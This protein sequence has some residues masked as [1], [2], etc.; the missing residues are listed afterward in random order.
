MKCP[1]CSQ[2]RCACEQAFAG[3]VYPTITSAVL[4]SFTADKLKSMHV[5]DI[6]TDAKEYFRLIFK[7]CRAGATKYQ[8]ITALHGFSVLFLPY[9]QS[10]EFNKIMK[11]YYEKENSALNS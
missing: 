8:V 1:L 3:I 2:I 7:F 10:L 5:P 6:G 4:L 9:M 11:I